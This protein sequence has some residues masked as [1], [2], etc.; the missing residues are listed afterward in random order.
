[1]AV[2]WKGFARR[3]STAPC[4]SGTAPGAVGPGWQH[5][6]MDEGTRHEPARD[7]EDLSRFVVE[8]LNA[9]DVDGLVAL[10]EPDAVMALPG[11]TA[12]GVQEIRTA[13]EQFVAGQ[14]GVVRGDQQ[15]TLRWGD[16]ALT[17]S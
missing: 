17:S 14:P 12:T 10:Y 7:P 4:G 9:G 13:Y 2:A 11:G 16:L 1:M 6:V 15:A 8:R 3:R 5:R